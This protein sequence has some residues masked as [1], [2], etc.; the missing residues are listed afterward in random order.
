MKHI[1]PLNY[2]ITSLALLLLLTACKPDVKP[3]VTY[4]ENIKKNLRLSHVFVPPSD[5]YPPYTLLHYIKG[6]GFQQVCEASEVTGIAEENL[7][8]ELVSK[9]LSNSTMSKAYNLN[10]GVA[11]AQKGVGYAGVDYQDIKNVVITLEKGKIISMPSVHISDVNRT[12]STGKCAEDIKFFTST[13]PN[14]KFFIPREVYQ[15]SMKYSILDKDG[16]NITAK[17]SKNLQKVVLA[18]AGIDVDNEE[19]M[20]MDGDELYI[21]FKGAAMSNGM[22]PKGI[23]EKSFIDVTQLVKSIQ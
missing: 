11:L 12:I 7:S 9:N 1:L 14:S 8:R 19:I 18:N 20:T 16:V 15:Y 21:G 4:E 10:Y 6:E 22:I 2:V 13:Q 5:A 23:R 3:T 17:L